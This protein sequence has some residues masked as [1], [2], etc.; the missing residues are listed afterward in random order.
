MRD[1][2]VQTAVVLLLLLIF[3]VDFHENSYT[4]RPRKRAHQAIDAIEEALFSGR[5]EVVDADFSGYFDT[6]PPVELMRLVKGRISD[7]SILRLI[8]GWLRATVVE[9]D[10]KGGKRMRANR[11]GTP[12]G[13]VC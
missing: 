12:Q 1:L 8:K 11:C 3:D 4:Y 7:G 2:V 5:R 10:P 9:E 13:G 6:I